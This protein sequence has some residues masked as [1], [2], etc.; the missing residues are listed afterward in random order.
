MA[1][2]R[3][4]DSLIAALVTIVTLAC[5]ST[6]RA[7]PDQGVS[8]AL[9]FA[10]G[11]GWTPGG[12]HLDA[13]YLLPLTPRD[14]VDVGF[15]L[16]LGAGGAACEQASA[17]DYTCHHDLVQGQA[18]AFQTGVRHR[19]GSEAAAA[20]PFAR[21]GASIIAIRYPDDVVATMTY[22]MDSPQPTKGMRG[23]AIAA[24]AG[25]GLLLPT[26]RATTIVLAADF[27]VGLGGFAGN[28]DGQTLLGFA[29]TAGVEVRP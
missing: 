21:G 18:L 4:L 25:G 16:T 2:R 26:S 19:F 9:G 24:H 8:A 11:G 1:A 13:A 14:L 5:A 20:Q 28:A 7:D 23:I 10:G 22:S 17:L 3:I 6:A 15:G 12:F 27:L 29:V